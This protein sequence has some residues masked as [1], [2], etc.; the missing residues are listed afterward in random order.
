[1]TFTSVLLFA[2]MLV[3]ICDKDIILL[4]LCLTQ[5]V[6]AFIYLLL[7]EDRGKNIQKS[8][9]R[10]RYIWYQKNIQVR[11]ILFW[12]RHT[13]L[14][15]MRR[16]A[17]TD[18]LTHWKVNLKRSRNIISYYL[19][20]LHVSLTTSNKREIFLSGTQKVSAKITSSLEK[21][22]TKKIFNQ[23]F[24]EINEE[25]TLGECEL[26]KIHTEKF[27]SQL[28]CQVSNLELGL[29]C[30]NLHNLIYHFWNSELPVIWS[31]V[32]VL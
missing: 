26:K 27:P 25:E 29:T 22:R 24:K 5:F 3:D 16:R 28:I 19:S 21:A 11:I 17:I 12:M 30:Y 9:T 14:L 23:Q 32:G 6:I 13:S 8:K 1:M 15:N 7:R 18:G 31:E 2:K 10:E 20:T 4:S